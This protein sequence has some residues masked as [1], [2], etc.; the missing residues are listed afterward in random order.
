[1]ALFYLQRGGPQMEIPLEPFVTSH[2]VEWF[3]QYQ[4]HLVVKDTP[5]FSGITLVASLYEIPDREL[6]ATDAVR[7][8]KSTK[9]GPTISRQRII[10]IDASFW[11]QWF[12]DPKYGNELYAYV[13]H[14]F[15]APEMLRQIQLIRQ[16]YPDP[17]Q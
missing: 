8:K 5:R 14:S 2:L 1:M 9:R 4:H 15:E 3:P 11:V 16:R 6:F 7:L 17:L 10:Y 13:S 12:R